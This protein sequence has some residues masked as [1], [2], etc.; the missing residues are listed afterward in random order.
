MTFKSIDLQMSIPRT[1]EA[2]GIH[3]QQ[4][5]RAANEQAMLA[6]DSQ[7]QAVKERQ[8]STGIEEA[9]GQTIRDREAGKQGGGQSRERRKDSK[10]A[11]EAA[12]AKEHPYKGKH[13][14]I[15]F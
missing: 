1:Q 6:G 11:E 4:L 10:S 14:D 7:K 2:S 5:Q 8:M 3:S 9:T 13:I 15:S 12:P